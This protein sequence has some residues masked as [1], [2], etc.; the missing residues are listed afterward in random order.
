MEETKNEDL[1]QEGKDV[2]PEM[3]AQSTETPAADAQE[4]VETMADEALAKLEVEKSIEALAEE[5]KAQESIADEV[6]EVV[7][8]EASTDKAKTEAVVKGVEETI[9]EE[10]KEE[11]LVDSA[12]ASSTEEVESDDNHEEDQ[13]AKE[14]LEIP[15]YSAMTN[16]TLIEE[17]SRLLQMN[18][19]SIKDHFEALKAALYKHLD[20]ERAGKLAEFIEA[21]NAEMDFEFIQ[22]IKDKFKTIYST[23]R[24]KRDAY[25]KELGEKLATNLDVKKAIIEEIKGLP[26]KEG[27]RVPEK[28]KQFR[29]LQDRWREVGP[30]PK[31]DSATLYNN[32]HF[33][34]NNFYDFLRISNELREMD[35]KKNLKAKEALCEQAEKM[36]EKD[37]QKGAFEELQKLHKAWKEIGPVD[38]EHSDA[39][40]ERF[41]QATKAIHNKR[42]EFFEK[43][44]LNQEEKLV[45][46]DV[47][48]KE[49]EEMV[50]KPVSTH[51]AWQKA[52]KELDSLRQKFKS[53]GP[54]HHPKNDEIWERFREANREFNRAKNNFY[55]GLKKQQSDNLNRKK[56]LLAKVEAIKDSDNWKDTAAELKRIQVQ[57]KKIGYVPKAE[58]D[59][60]WEEFRN[61]CNHFF[62]R[63]TNYNN[64]LDEAFKENLVKKQAML[65]EVEAFEISEDGKAD[66]AKLQEMIKTWR[67]HGRVPR[68][69]KEIETTFSQIIDKKFESLKIE[70]NQGVLMRFENKL[71]SFL[72]SND[73][74][75]L[76]KEFDLVR[77]KIDEAKKEM[78][79][80]Q[81]NI[82]FFAHVDDSNPMVKE[83][84]K[85]ISRLEEQVESLKAKL[86]HGRQFVKNF[87][88]AKEEPKAEEPNTEN[89]EEKSED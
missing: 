44:K 27:V 22:P 2:N 37:I 24:S 19:V 6:T 1:N 84:N 49:I 35:F 9:S 14:E 63:L 8:E 62:N 13:F 17:A 34:V 29:E 41:S 65:K 38:R 72:D 78:M 82:S 53:F 80:L 76:D 40:W 18:I 20:D 5:A 77:R 30:V 32:Y 12:K 50:K 75:K 52:I 86:S 36:S 88:A 57:W 23:Y 48:C 21:G 70:K 11:V 45:E 51:G 43:L 15:D 10:V 54:I 87:N 33:H 64:G 28:Y 46:K 79:Q 73:K 60:I 68:A 31:S 25:Y 16:E 58:S 47:V 81:N 55:K 39:V 42:H 4:K 71:A 89:S 7:A 67:S 66:M 3:E 69:D 59:K 61:A 83:V 26:N 74:F 56:E 85:N